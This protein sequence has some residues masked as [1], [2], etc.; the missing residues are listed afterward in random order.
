MQ[1]VTLFAPW[2][3]EPTNFSIAYSSLKFNR[4]TAFF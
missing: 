2:F 3:S 4:F 1:T